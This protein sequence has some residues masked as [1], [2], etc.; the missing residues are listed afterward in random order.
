MNAKEAKT[1]LDARTKRISRRARPG[2]TWE[3][4][5]SQV[6][7]LLKGRAR[8]KSSVKGSARE[9]LARVQKLR[10]ARIG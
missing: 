9:R 2:R 1:R 8:G 4:Q 6:R 10:G 3:K 7:S 5:L